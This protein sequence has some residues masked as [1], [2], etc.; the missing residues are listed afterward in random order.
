MKKRNIIQPGT[1]VLYID[2][3]FAIGYGVV[4]HATVYKCGVVYKLE[5]RSEDFGQDQIDITASKL[6]AKINKI[7]KGLVEVENKMKKSLQPRPV[8]HLENTYTK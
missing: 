1:H 8:R 6:K 4:E 5:G 2:S 7:T 3:N